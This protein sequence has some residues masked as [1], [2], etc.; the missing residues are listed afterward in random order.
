MGTAKFITEVLKEINEDV[1]LLTEK[2]KK[3]GTGSPLETIFTAAFVP[4]AK[5]LLPEGVPPYKP[6]AAPMGM[7]RARFIH[8]VKSFKMFQR[9]YISKNRRD[10]LFIQLCEAIHP[11]EVVILTA[12]KDQTLTELYPNITYKVLAEAGYV[13]RNETLEAAPKPKTTRKKKDKDGD[14]PE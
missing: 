11:D 8:E 6:D 10:M 14:K 1:S 5:F 7:S 2:Y 9:A 12:I 13:P 3:Q 4:S